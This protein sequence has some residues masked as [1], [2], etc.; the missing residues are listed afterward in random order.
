MYTCQI[1]ERLIVHVTVKDGGQIMTHEP[2][3]KRHWNGGHVTM[4][5]WGDVRKH[6]TIW[7]IG[8][9]SVHLIA[10]IK[11]LAVLHVLF[12]SHV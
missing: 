4:Y 3:D 5:G 11:N 10:F 6:F 12:Q 7:N 9:Y 2:W 1:K 8:I